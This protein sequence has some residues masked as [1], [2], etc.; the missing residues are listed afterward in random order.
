MTVIREMG[1]RGHVSIPIATK[2][3]TA[4]GGGDDYDD[5]DEILQFEDGESRYILFTFN[6]TGSHKCLIQVYFCV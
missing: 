1:A 6:I 2:P 5:I 4:K 3:G